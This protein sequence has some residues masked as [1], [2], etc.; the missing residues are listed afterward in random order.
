MLQNSYLQ[1][2]S[3]DIECCTPK[4]SN[5]SSK[6]QKYTHHLSVSPGLN[7]VI[8]C[9]WIAPLHCTDTEFFHRKYPL[10]YIKCT[11][12]E[13]CFFPVRSKYD[14]CT[15][16]TSPSCCW[17]QDLAS[18]CACHFVNQAVLVPGTTPINLLHLFI[19]HSK[20]TNG[21]CS[22]N[23]DLLL[24]PAEQQYHLRWT[25]STDLAAPGKNCD[26]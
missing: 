12:L 10:P 14:H 11:P 23:L 16:Y 21:N 8:P 7:W 13:M 9:M 18:W 6:F 5:S 20:T 19:M 17:W 3:T 22:L 26:L 1:L 15:F 4:F 25:S 2:P 24:F